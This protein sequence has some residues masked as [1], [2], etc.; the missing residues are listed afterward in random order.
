MIKYIALVFFSIHISLS[1]GQWLPLGYGF[2]FPGR[3]LYYDSLSNNIIVGGNFT[4]ADSIRVNFITRWNGNSWDSL[5]SGA[6]YGPIV[7]V[8]NYRGSLFASAIFDNLSLNNYL[9]KW[10]GLFWDSLSPNLDGKVMCFYENNNI[11]YIG[12]VFSSI[13]NV[14]SPLFLSYNDTNFIPLNFPASGYSVNAIEYFQGNIF[15]GGN[16]FDTL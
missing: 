16:F 10:T 13:G 9:Y 4:T 1:Y 8:I 3:V 14:Y 15:L 11:L 2:N 6:D 5:G 12:G 7:S